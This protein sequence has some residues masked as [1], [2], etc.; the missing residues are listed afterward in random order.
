M[1]EVDLPSAARINL[2]H[3]ENEHRFVLHI[4]YSTPIRQ[5]NASVIEDLVSLSNIKV[6]FNFQKKFSQ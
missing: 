1:I 4:L 2:L 6:S 5:G 3:Q